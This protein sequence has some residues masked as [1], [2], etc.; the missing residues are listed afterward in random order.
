VVQFFQLVFITYLLVKLIKKGSMPF[1]WFE[2]E[3]PNGPTVVEIT[4][5]ESMN[6]NGETKK[7]MLA[8]QDEIAAKYPHGTVRLLI[9]MKPFNMFSSGISEVMTRAFIKELLE[10]STNFAMVIPHS[11]NQIV[12]LVVGTLIAA[13]NTPYRERILFI[14]QRRKAVETA[15]GERAS[16]QKK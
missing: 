13:S 16:S 6:I 10:M 9:D 2:I 11:G 15:K 4:S 7:A 1:Q 5:S 8:I 14:P 3:N 12:N